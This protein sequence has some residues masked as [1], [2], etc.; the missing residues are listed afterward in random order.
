MSF[1]KNHWLIPFLFLCLAIIGLNTGCVNFVTQGRQNSAY[2]GGYSSGQKLELLRDCFVAR[3]DDGLDGYRHI[4]LPQGDV[5][6]PA[7]LHPAPVKISYWNKGGTNEWRFPGIDLTGVIPA[8]TVIE[9]CH[10]KVNRG[11]SWWA[12]A[13][14]TATVYGKIIDGEFHGLLVDMSDASVLRCD[15]MREPNPILLSPI[16]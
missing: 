16:N 10:V 13:H 1:S 6:T 14:R 12:G 8:G 15:E 5:W 7:R 11:W 4:L 9:I 2:W 3:V